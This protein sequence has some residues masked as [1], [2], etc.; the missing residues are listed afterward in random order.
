MSK[1]RGEEYVV[2]SLLLGFDFQNVFGFA[3]VFILGFLRAS[4]LLDVVAIQITPI[5]GIPRNW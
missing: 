1:P 3:S 2:P 5:A 4:N